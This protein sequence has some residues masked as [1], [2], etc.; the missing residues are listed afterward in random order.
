MAVCDVAVRSRAALDAYTRAF[1]P[2]FAPAERHVCTN[3]CALWEHRETA[4]HVCTA[5]LA[6]HACGDLCNERITTEEFEVCCLT[7]RVVGALNAVHHWQRKGPGVVQSHRMPKKHVSLAVLK[8]D[9]Y[10]AV[11]EQTVIAL[12]T[13][14]ARRALQQDHKAR[15][16]RLATQ[17]CRKK[18]SLR[19]LYTTV[20]TVAVNLARQLQPITTDSKTVRALAAKV[21]AYVVKFAAVLKTTTAAAAFAAAVV[22]KM[23]VGHVVKSVV[24]IPRVP[25]V[26]RHAPHPID[27]KHILNLR[28]RMISSACRLLTNTVISTAGGP[29]SAY[30]FPAFHVP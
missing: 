30:V 20:G 21:G 26:A 15:L 27:H 8:A 2:R 3:R 19:H 24:I 13:S 10:R 17:A 22:D 29:L 7:G 4:C 1:K 23:V 25:F 14:D 18:R 12:F 28:C 16:L 5:S 11:A 6:V 9:R